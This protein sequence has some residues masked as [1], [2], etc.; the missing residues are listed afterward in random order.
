[1]SEFDDEREQAR[2]AL[3]QIGTRLALAGFIPFL[4]LALWLSAIAPDHPWRGETILLLKAYGAVILSFLGG[5][6]FGLAIASGAASDRSALTL[7]MV[8]ALAA[9]AALWIAEPYAFALLAVAFAAHGAWDNLAAHA[10]IA[11]AWF[12]RMRVWLTLLVVGAMVLAFLAT[13]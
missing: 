9:W 4:L 10:G 8:P 11:P 13:A 3:Q 6:R 12:G 7:S 5:I 1:M 2:P